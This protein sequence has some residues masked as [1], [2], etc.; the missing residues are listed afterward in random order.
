M[1]RRRAREPETLRAD[2]FGM[3]RL[4][5]VCRWLEDTRETSMLLGN[6]S[7]RRFHCHALRLHDCSRGNKNRSLH[8]M[9]PH[10][11]SCLLYNLLWRVLL[12]FSFSAESIIKRI[13][14]AAAWK[15]FNF[16]RAQ[17]KK[18]E[19]NGAVLVC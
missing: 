9:R 14:I 11:W 19:E 10:C 2:Q 18:T 8:S 3:S 15:I 1:L 13:F 5:K 16:F 17:I 12:P 6:L 4:A 7:A